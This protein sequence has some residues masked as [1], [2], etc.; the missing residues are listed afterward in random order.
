M[1]G[2]SF[3]VLDVLGSRA[4]RLV[5]LVVAGSVLGG[6]FLWTSA[7]EGE[8]HERRI[9]TLEAGF[10]N[11][12]AQLRTEITKAQGQVHELQGVLEK[13]TRVVTRNS[14]DTGAQVEE[15]RTQLST[16]EGQVA[17]IKNSLEQL[18]REMAA[19][20]TE[21]NQRI[22]QVAR[23]AGLDM[24]VDASQIPADRGEHFAAGERAHRAGEYSKARAIFR[25]YLTRYPQDDHAD[26]AQ[27]MIGAS[28]LQENRPATALGELRK[29]LSDYAQGDAIDEALFDM[30]E[31]FWRLHA[32]TDARGALEAL[33]RTQASSPLVGQARTK[34]RQVQHPARGYCTS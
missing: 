13:A 31:A 20:R 29:V 24:P 9:A 21:V 34:L 27:Y 4:A 16:L 5:A 33:I 8:E 19:Q 3:V 2:G 23:K 14:A 22:E 6:C 28:Y 30:A 17:E 18:G 12:R 10:R 26:N 1:R 15:M 25:E 11:E 7:G 32:C